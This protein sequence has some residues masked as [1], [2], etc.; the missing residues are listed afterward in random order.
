VPTHGL[1]FCRRQ[2]N[3]KLLGAHDHILAR[4]YRRFGGLVIVTVRVLVISWYIQQR[5]CGAQRLR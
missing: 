5:F 3:D 4:F 2:K 1:S